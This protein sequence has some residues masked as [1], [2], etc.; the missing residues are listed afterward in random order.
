MPERQKAQQELR[1]LNRLRKLCSKLPEVTEAVDGFGHTSFRVANKPFTMMGSRELH[2]AIKADPFTQEALVRS[3]RYTRTPFLGK[4]GWVSVA[5]FKQ[6][7]WAE[8]E[9]LVRDAYGRVAPKRLR[10]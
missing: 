8:I 4:H 1:I 9:E 2:L 3:G 7:D 6:L 5:D 10:K